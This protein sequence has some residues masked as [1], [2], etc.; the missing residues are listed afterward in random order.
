MGYSAKKRE[1]NRRW[2]RANLDRI[3]VACPAGTKAR[4]EQAADK[5]G[6]SINGWI[7]GVL[8]DRL[9][10]EVQNQADKDP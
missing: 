4:I 5:S 9:N 1:S 3:S 8:L 6:M 10:E 2:D 7:K